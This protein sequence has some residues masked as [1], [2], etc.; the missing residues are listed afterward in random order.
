MDI[1]NLGRGKGKTTYLLMK[2]HMTQI[3]ILTATISSKDYIKIEAERIGLDI[4]EP[5]SV[6]DLVGDNSRGKIKPYRL[7][8]DEMPAVLQAVLGITIDTAT[9]TERD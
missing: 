5:L 2:S 8:V 1:L 7:L 3:P 4:P 9:M 6:K